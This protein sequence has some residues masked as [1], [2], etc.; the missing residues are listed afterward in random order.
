[1][2]FQKGFNSAFLLFVRPEAHG[3]TLDLAIR[4]G[5]VVFGNGRLPQCSGTGVLL[6][7]TTGAGQRG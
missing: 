7:G 5:F 3:P 2:G 1:M 6:N 4:A